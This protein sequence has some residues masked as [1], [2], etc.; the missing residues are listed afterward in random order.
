MVSGLYR[1]LGFERKA[2]EENGDS[3]WVRKI[4]DTYENRN[5]I[6]EILR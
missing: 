1:D 2:I 3:V 6:I 4:P 5:H